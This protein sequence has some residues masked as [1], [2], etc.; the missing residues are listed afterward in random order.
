MLEENITHLPE[1]NFA[2]LDDLS[3]AQVV[4]SA[5]HPYFSHHKVVGHKVLPGVVYLELAMQAAKLLYPTFNIDSLED[6]VWMQPI[7]CVAESVTLK[8]LLC[9]DGFNLKYQLCDDDKVYAHGTLCQRSSVNGP[10][11]VGLDAREQVAQNSLRRISRRQSYQAFSDM[12]IDYGRY[13]QRINYV[14]IHHNQAIALLSDND[15]SIITL[16]NLLDCSFQSG[17]AIS[18]GEHQDALMPFSLGILKFHQSPE[19]LNK[20]SYYVLTRKD[21]PFRT[22]ITIFDE[23]YQP[24]IS[25]YDLGVKATLLSTQ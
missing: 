23:E 25:V 19:R 9:V 4:L 7:V 14:D 22:N 18:I 3:G 13:F 6:S 20:H 11:S 12:G 21:S 2:V 16:A 10:P 5:E 15:G 17:M 24:M 1:T 8:V